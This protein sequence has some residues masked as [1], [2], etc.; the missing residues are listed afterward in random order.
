MTCCGRY[1]G[2]FGSCGGRRL[3]RDLEMTTLTIL[4]MFT[5]LVLIVIGV[6]LGRCAG[7]LE[8]CADALEALDVEAFK[9]QE[10]K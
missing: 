9:T 5:L 10:K 3:D 7:A 6:L 1:G 4:A 2:S 8:R